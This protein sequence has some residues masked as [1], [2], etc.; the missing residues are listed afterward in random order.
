MPSVKPSDKVAP[1]ALNRNLAAY[2]NFVNL[3]DYA[4]ISVPSSIRPDGLPF[5]ITLIGRCGA[6]LQLA[7]PGQRYHHTSG[8]TLGAT[9]QPLPAPVDVFAASAR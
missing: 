2:T 9:G 5:G 7:E 8:L 4:A 1:V 3:L 6:G